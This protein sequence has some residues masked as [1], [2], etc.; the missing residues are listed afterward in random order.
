[1]IYVDLD[2]FFLSIYNINGPK[3]YN[4]TS[5]PCHFTNNGDTITNVL[6]KDQVHIKFIRQFHQFCTYLFMNYHIVVSF[7]CSYRFVMAVETV[8]MAVTRGQCATQ[9]LKKFHTQLDTTSQQASHCTFSCKSLFCS[10]YVSMYKSLVYQS[11]QVLPL[12]LQKKS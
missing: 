12:Y 4:Y 7:Y 6:R 3:L 1:M 9:V 8:K 5:K 2:H 11:I 10:S